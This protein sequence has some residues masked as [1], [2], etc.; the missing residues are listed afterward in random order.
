LAVLVLGSGKSADV[1]AQGEVLQG[2]ND[3]YTS[4]K[5]GA[6]ELL[7]CCLCQSGWVMCLQDP[8]ISI[9]ILQAVLEVV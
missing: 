3:R 5:G 9:D 7:T 6:G 8:L 1:D 4:V 2:R